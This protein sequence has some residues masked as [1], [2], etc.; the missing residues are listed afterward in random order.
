MINSGVYWVFYPFQVH[1]GKKGK[2]TWRKKQLHI[3]EP[4]FAGEPHL[5]TEKAMAPHSSTPAW[6]IPWAEEPGRLQSTG[7]RTVG[8]D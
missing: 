3:F 4:T 8:H 6:E 5:A 1:L 7:S 2:F